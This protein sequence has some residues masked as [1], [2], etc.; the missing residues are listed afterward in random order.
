MYRLITDSIKGHEE[1]DFQ[2]LEEAQAHFDMLKN[3]GYFGIE[4][5]YTHEIVEVILEKEDV[6]PRQ[7][8]LA[9]L[10]VG[11]TET[12]IDVAI[13]LL[14][15]PSKEQAAIAWKYSLSYKRS[16]SAVTVIGS[17]AGLSNEQLDSLWD[18]AKGL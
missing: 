9:L 7:L 6:S 16:E 5:E 13:S 18:L 8:R 15:S 12:M 14:E 11:I 2:T 17:L 10:S 1:S 4:G 3:S